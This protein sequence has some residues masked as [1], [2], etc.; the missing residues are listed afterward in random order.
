MK[1]CLS[2]LLSLVLVLSLTACQKG[3]TP[4]EVPTV[5][6]IGSVSFSGELYQLLRMNAYQADPKASKKEMRQ[7]VLQEMERYAAI[8]ESFTQL[9]GE[10]GTK[11][12]N[13]VNQYTQSIWDQS[14]ETMS[15][16][17]ITRETLEAYVAHLYRADQMLELFYGETGAKPLTDQDILNYV[18]ENFYYGTCIYLPLT[19]S[20]GEDIREDEEAMEAVRQAAGRI[21]SDVSGGTSPDDA[22]QKELADVLALTGG[23]LDD[24]GTASYVYANMYTPFNWQASL[25]QSSIETL[26]TAEIG[27]CVVLEN[28]GD[29]T[30]FLRTDPQ[31]SYTADEMRS[32]ATYYMKNEELQAQLAQTGAE[33]PHDL[34]ESAMDSLWASALKN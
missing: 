6:T 27:D 29:I 2:A 4:S 24:E 32:Y 16:N 1:R 9:G 7:S 18:G 5:G 11:G 19:G 8:E 31:E 28:D 23:A 13:Y 12:Q 17:G 10:M 22:A 30:V 14:G 26:Q 25:S 15:A 33:L 34:D 3:A 20:N 21:R